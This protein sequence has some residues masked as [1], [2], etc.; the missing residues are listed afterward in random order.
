MCRFLT[1][2]IAST[3]ILI[4]QPENYTWNPKKKKKEKEL[5]EEHSYR[6]YEQTVFECLKKK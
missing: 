3:T 5:P 1:G 4:I 6:W 2:E